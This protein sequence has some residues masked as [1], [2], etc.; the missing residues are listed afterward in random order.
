MTIRNDAVAYKEKADAEKKEVIQM[1]EQAEYNDIQL[2][3]TQQTI[4]DE[5]SQIM[6]LKLRLE[7]EKNKVQQQ[8]NIRYNR[9]LKIEE[10]NDTI[11][12]FMADKTKLLKGKKDMTELMQSMEDDM[13]MLENMKGS[14]AAKKSVVS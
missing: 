14:G 8:S 6:Q 10:Q 11:Q 3:D 9:L 12:Q 2:K 5:A 13:S 1:S 7:T 4:D